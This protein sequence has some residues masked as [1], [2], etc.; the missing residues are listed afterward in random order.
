MWNIMAWQCISPEVTVQGQM[1]WMRL[2][3]M[4]SDYEEDRCVRRMTVKGM[5]ILGMNV[6]KM[7]A[8]NMQ[9]ETMTLIGNGK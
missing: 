7:K 6:R 8:L 3:M 5:D 4:W 9:M 1:Q 2:M